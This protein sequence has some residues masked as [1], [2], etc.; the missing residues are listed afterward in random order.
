MTTPPLTPNPNNYAFTDLDRQNA[1]GFQFSMTQYF[2]FPDDDSE[3]SLDSSPESASPSWVRT[4]ATI[5]S[6]ECSPLEP[7]PVESFEEPKLGPM[8]TLLSPLTHDEEFLNPRLI[9]RA[10][11]EQLKELHIGKYE[12]ANANVANNV[13]HNSSIEGSNNG[14]RDLVLKDAKRISKEDSSPEE[15]EAF[16]DVLV[17]NTFPS[18]FTSQELGI[19]MS[20]IEGTSYDSLGNRESNQDPDGIQIVRKRRLAFGSSDSYAEKAYFAEQVREQRANKSSG[21]D[22]LVEDNLDNYGSLTLGFS[23]T[24][25]KSPSN[26]EDVIALPG[27]KS[28]GD[29]EAIVGFTFGV[30]KPTRISGY[31][32][33]TRRHTMGHR[34]TKTLIPYLPFTTGMLAKGNVW[35]NRMFKKKKFFVKIKFFRLDTRREMAATARKSNPQETD[36]AL[37]HLPPAF[38]KEFYALKDT[39]F[40]LLDSLKA[41]Y[42]PSK[43]APQAE[44]TMS[45]VKV[46][47]APT[48]Y[49]SCRIVPLLETAGNEDVGLCTVFND[50]RN[51]RYYSRLN[52]YELLKILGFEAYHIQLTK[53]V[54]LGVLEIFKNYCNFNLGYQTWI[55]DTTKEERVALVNKLYSYTRV[56]YPEIDRFKLEVIIRRG[57]YSLMQSR[58]RRERR[59]SSG[60]INRWIEHQTHVPLS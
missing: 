45:L 42:P 20:A 54:E 46:P 57:S 51:D 48:L 21:S 18:P 19:H 8:K 26:S 59:L 41:K 49:G 28:F 32:K 33:N 39:K 9:E 16:E 43:M 3:L 44:E 1:Y 36:L 34:R 14:K 13:S 50:L 6:E 40:M 12:F 5:T 11:I 17:L 31:H 37:K 22:D 38:S 56:F 60:W 4:A 24:Y 25:D 27:T 15:A 23:H 10:T 52:I 35:L 7:K 2:R 53:E 55:R 47:S 30:E 58:L 29:M